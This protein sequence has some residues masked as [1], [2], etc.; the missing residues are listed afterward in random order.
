M[1]SL[2]TV[3]AAL[4]ATLS[5][6]QVPLDPLQGGAY[7][8]YPDYLDHSCGG[9][10]LVVI[11]DAGTVAMVKATTT[12]PGS[13]R[14]AKPRN[15]LACWKVTFASDRYYILDRERV[16]YATWPYGQA[17]YACPVLQ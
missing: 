17:G 11:E 13:G 3:I 16:L 6:A 9:V 7:R 15:Y 2:F 10:K 5:V 14:G 4:L 8:A 12:C 1:K